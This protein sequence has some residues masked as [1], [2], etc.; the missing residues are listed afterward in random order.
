MSVLGWI[1][2]FIIWVLRRVLLIVAIVVGVL[3]AHWELTTSPN[4]VPPA[5]TWSFK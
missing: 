4:G 5:S 3:I 2:T 1:L